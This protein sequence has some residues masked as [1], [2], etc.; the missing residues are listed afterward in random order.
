MSVQMSWDEVPSASCG[1]NDDDG[2]VDGA[3]VDAAVASGASFCSSP[4]SAAAFF[5]FFAASLLCAISSAT[6]SD[7]SSE[8]NASTRGTLTTREP[9]PKRC[10]VGAM[11][12]RSTSVAP[13]R[14]SGRQALLSSSSNRRMRTGAQR[15][16]AQ[17]SRSRRLSVFLSASP[18]TVRIACRSDACLACAARST[19]RRRSRT[20]ARAPR[21]LQTAKSECADGASTPSDSN[22]SV[23]T[24]MRSRPGGVSCTTLQW[25]MGVPTERPNTEPQVRYRLRKASLS[26]DENGTVA[27]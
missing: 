16:S 24:Y 11:S 1:K 15:E 23:S 3:A 26:R 12:M 14:S 13:A 19:V 9:A 7:G 27:S 4:A 20:R 6:A 8:V 22:A 2:A 10:T 5:A 17:R 21:S 25:S 18:S